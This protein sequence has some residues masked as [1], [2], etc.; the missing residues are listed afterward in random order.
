MCSCHSIL[1]CCVTFS[2]VKLSIRSF[3]LFPSS[4]FVTGAELRAHFV[5]VQTLFSQL[6][7]NVSSMFQPNQGNSQSITQ[8]FALSFVG[9]AP[10][11]PFAS[12]FNCSQPH[13]SQVSSSTQLQANLSVAFQSNM[14]NFCLP[15]SI[16]PDLY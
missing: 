15:P 11:D 10:Q 9:L 1:E 3:V 8:P 4:D 14:S 2:G 12:S 5:T 16:F 7:D 13:Y 6:K